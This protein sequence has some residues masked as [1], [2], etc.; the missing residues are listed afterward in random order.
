MLPTL[1]TITATIACTLLTG[2]TPPLKHVRPCVP[3][4]QCV[5]TWT[6]R[7]RTRVC[8]VVIPE[9]GPET[10]SSAARERSSY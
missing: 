10:R 4:E 7:P 1:V 2:K 9:T 3:A 6:F 8:G 5:E